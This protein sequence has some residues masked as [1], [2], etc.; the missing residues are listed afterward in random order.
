MFDAHEDKFLHMVAQNA[1]NNTL[2][3]R[4]PSLA[5]PDWYLT[6][7]C[8]VQTVWNIL[9][10]HSPEY[11]ISDY[12]VFYCDVENLTWEAEDVIIKRCAD[13]FSDLDVE[14]QIRNQAR[15][16]L[17]YEQ[18]HGVPY[19]PLQ[20]SREGIDSFLNQSSCFGVR[21]E[22]GGLFEVYAP[23]G[24]TDLFAMTLR[25]NGQQNLPDVYYKKARRWT[26]MW[27]KL[28]VLPW[29]EDN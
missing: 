1:I 18:K 25:P 13:A 17:W 7:G 5:L 19:P 29:P 4:L 27:P 9:S 26:Q 2:L 14:V 23:F 10:G 28:K 3:E 6:A 20:S 21:R 11:G 12:D 24:F 15:V 8:L 22:P 16:H